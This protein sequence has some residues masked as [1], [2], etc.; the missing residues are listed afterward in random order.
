VKEIS[1]ENITTNFSKREIKYLTENRLARIATVSHDQQPHVVPINYKFDGGY[2]YFSGWNLK[3]TLKFRNIQKNNK[4]ALVID[5]VFSVNPWRTRAVVIEG[6][7]EIMKNS[8]DD[9]IRITPIRK[10]SWGI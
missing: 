6:I 2:F 3:G 5:D 1:H 7:A 4:V 8:N 10:V 9:Y